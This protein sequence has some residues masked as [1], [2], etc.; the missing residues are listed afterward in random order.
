MKTIRWK[1]AKPEHFFIIGH[2]RSGT[3]LLY[4]ILASQREMSYFESRINR[5]AIHNL[6]FFLLKYSRMI[7]DYPLRPK[8]LEGGRIWD[9]FHKSYDYVTFPEKNEVK[10]IKSAIKASMN[11]LSSKI[12]LAKYPSLNLRLRMLNKIFPTAKF[13]L[14][15]RDLKA[16]IASYYTKMK[17]LSSSPDPYDHWKRIKSFGSSDFESCINIYKYTNFILKQDL[18][19]IKDRTYTVQYS[20]LVGAPSQTLDRIC[21]FL[22]IDAE[23]KIPDIDHTTS[24]KWKSLPID[25]QKQL[26]ELEGL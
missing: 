2:P 26:L 5:L 6:P 21:N 1:L 8:P 18:P 16:S 11:F 20:E 14:I 23:Y 22:E 3:T 10:Y 25:H 17:N 9:Q 13:I 12:F 7:K 24:E 19:V 4:E 15:E